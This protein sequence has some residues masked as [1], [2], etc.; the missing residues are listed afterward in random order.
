MCT[1][2][3]TCCRKAIRLYLCNE[4]PVLLAEATPFA[5]AGAVTM[6]GSG[7][8]YGCIRLHVPLTVEGWSDALIDLSPPALRVVPT[9]SNLK[10]NTEVMGMCR[11][12][13]VPGR[14]RALQ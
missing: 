6:H 4:P 7:T 12:M 1:E 5:A 13:C 3:S 10:R 14:L 11:L 8:F 2:Y 9:L